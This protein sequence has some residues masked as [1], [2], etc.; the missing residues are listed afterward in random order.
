MSDGK[1]KLKA[2]FA[3]ADKAKTNLKTQNLNGARRYQN[4]AL[5]T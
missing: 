5:T 1:L 4:F 3:E 2:G